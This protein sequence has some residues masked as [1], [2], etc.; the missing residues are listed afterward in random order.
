MFQLLDDIRQG[1]DTA[2]CQCAILEHYLWPVMV[3]CSLAYIIMTEASVSE[4]Q[5]K[6]QIIVSAC[7]I[8][9]Q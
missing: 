2:L 3:T 5:I 6:F 7:C 4:T 9:I 1:I 8:C